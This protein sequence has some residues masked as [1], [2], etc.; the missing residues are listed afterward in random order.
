MR[1]SSGLEEPG[2]LGRQADTDCHMRSCWHHLG[3]V[4][5]VGEES[6]AEGRSKRAGE[7]GGGGEESLAEGRRSLGAA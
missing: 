1:R 6:E 5:L 2:Y 7:L 3:V 4:A